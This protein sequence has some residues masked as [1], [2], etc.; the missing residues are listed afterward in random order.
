MIYVMCLVE[1]VLTY[2][3]NIYRFRMALFEQHYDKYHLARLMA[4]EK[5]VFKIYTIF[6]TWFLYCPN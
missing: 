1:F 4:E 6:L 2:E 3:T 5:K